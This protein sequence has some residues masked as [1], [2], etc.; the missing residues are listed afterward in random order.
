M[1]T[2]LK[3]NRQQQRYDVTFNGGRSYC[4]CFSRRDA[5]KIAFALN[6]SPRDWDAPLSQDEKDKIRDLLGSVQNLQ[7]HEQTDSLVC[8][9]RARQ[10]DLI[11]FLSEKHTEIIPR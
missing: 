1:Y 7:P 11:S 8:L 4:R 3:S 6:H 5:E 9:T 10:Q 2:V